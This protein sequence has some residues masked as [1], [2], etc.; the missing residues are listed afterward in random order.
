MPIKTPLNSWH[1]FDDDND[2]DKIVEQDEPKEVP[3]SIW[4]QFKADGKTLD[5]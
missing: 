1:M 5:I 3:A 2:E 4:Y